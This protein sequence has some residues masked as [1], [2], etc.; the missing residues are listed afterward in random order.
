MNKTFVMLSGLPRSGSTVLTS[1]LNQHP[2]IHASTTSPLADF[3]ISSIESWPVLAQQMAEKPP[4]QMENII[5]GVVDGAYKHID[6][7]VIIDKNRLWPRLSQVMGSTLQHK[8]KII[9]TVRSIPEILSSYIILF[10]K[11]PDQ[12]NFVDEDLRQNGIPINT[13]T[14]CKLLWEKF[15]NH[16]YKSLLMGHNSKQCDILYL[17]YD[18]IVGDGQGTLDKICEFIG[19]DYYQLDTENLQPMD[20]ND[21]YHGFVGLHDVR[22]ELKR[23]SPRA[24]DV[25]GKD[26]VKLYT[27]MKLDFW[28]RV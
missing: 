25:I 21:K 28:N 24:E 27:D 1:M 9:C 13:K 5:E 12:P 2:S 26:L 23:T 10:A 14:R 16:P 7:P 11:K 6:K 22:K 18:D 17:N 3:L 15:I 4:R 8:P 20:E 19:I